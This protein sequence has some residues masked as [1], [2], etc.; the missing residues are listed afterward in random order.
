MKV[1]IANQ[2]PDNPEETREVYAIE[3]DI[4]DLEDASVPKLADFSASIAKAATVGAEDIRVSQER[5]RRRQAQAALEAAFVTAAEGVYQ[6]YGVKAGYERPW[7]YQPKTKSS[8]ELWKRVI[9][10]FIE[11]DTILAMGPTA[12]VSWLNSTGAASPVTR[13]MI[14][15]PLNKLAKGDLAKLLV[16]L[17]VTLV[18][19]KGKVTVRSVQQQLQQRRNAALG[20]VADEFLGR[21]K[22]EGDTVFVNG[23]PYK[24]QQ[25]TSGKRRVKV[26]GKDWLGLDALKAFC[27]GPQ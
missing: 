16:K 18:L 10:L 9:P 13:D 12:L 8:Y 22:I 4:S 15:D 19:P 1:V 7:V 23:R 3:L 21:F 17:G 24:I 5:E 2:D 26:G 14:Y 20:L 6:K 25:G 11:R 27:V